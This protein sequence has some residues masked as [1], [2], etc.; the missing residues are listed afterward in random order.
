MPIDNVLTDAIRV[1]GENPVL[2]NAEELERYV[3]R[4]RNE[5]PQLSEEDD[6]ARRGAAIEGFAKYAQLLREAASGVRP[7]RYSFKLEFPDGRWDLAEQ[8]LSKEPRVGDLVWFE[9]TPWQILGHREVPRRPSAARPHQFL[10][11]APAA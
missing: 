3:A 7:A 4:G 6:R 8:E 5:L 9:G 11:C 2:G 1:E 10:A